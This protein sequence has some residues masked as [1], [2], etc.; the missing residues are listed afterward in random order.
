MLI[1]PVKNHGSKQ[2][3]DT[4]ANDANIELAWGLGYEAKTCDLLSFLQCFS[5]AITIS[6]CT[7]DVL[8]IFGVV[9][10]GFV[11]ELLDCFEVIRQSASLNLTSPKVLV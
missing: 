8:Q 4:S 1:E 6:D 3:G 11:D 9:L 7:L 10:P 5:D 2:T